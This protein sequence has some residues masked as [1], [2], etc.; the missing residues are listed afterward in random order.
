ME[1]IN[2]NIGNE[3]ITCG[4]RTEWTVSEVGFRAGKR[5]LHP[6][7]WMWCWFR[8]GMCSTPLSF[9][10][11]HSWYVQYV[12]WSYFRSFAHHFRY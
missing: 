10:M 8:A 9:F 11:Y 12:H 5:G 6:W 2:G 3:Y 7:E 1:H 4:L